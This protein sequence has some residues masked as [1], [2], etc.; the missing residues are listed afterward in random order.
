MILIRKIRFAVLSVLFFMSMIQESLTQANY[1]NTYNISDKE[2]IYFDD[3]SSNKGLKAVNDGV[4]EG[5]YQY[6]SFS[7][8]SNSTSYIAMSQLN[9]NINQSRDFEIEIDIKVVS[10]SPSF[11][12]GLI[13]GMDEYDNSYRFG[14]T[15]DG[16][17]KIYKKVEGFLREVKPL[18]Y[19]SL[20]NKYDYN[21]LTVRKVKDTYYFFINKTLVHSTAFEPFYGNNHYIFTFT[22]SHI[23]ISSIHL[24]YIARSNSNTG[25]I[26]YY[27]DFS[28]DKGLKANNDGYSKGVYNYKY[29]Q[30]SSESNIYLGELPLNKYINQSKDFQIE[31][32]MKFVSGRDNNGNGIRWGKS[33]SNYFYFQ[34]SGNGQFSIGKRVNNQWVDL[35]PWTKSS[36]VNTLNYNKLTIRKISSRYYFFINE[37]LVHE[38]YFE[39]F[40]GDENCLYSNI[41]STVHISNINITYFKANLKKNEIENLSATSTT[42]NPSFTTKQNKSVILDKVEIN[43]KYTVVTMTY[44]TDSDNGQFWFEKGAYIKANQKFYYL[45]KSDVG[46]SQ[47]DCNLLKNKG[48]SKTFKLYFLRIEEGIENI[49]IWESQSEG[50]FNFSG[51]KINNKAK[52]ADNQTFNDYF[53]AGNNATNDKN[54]E[55]SVYYFS[56]ALKIQPN[57]STAYN[58]RS[59]AKYLMGQCSGAISDADKSISLGGNEFSY[60][61]RASIYLCLDRCRDA[62]ND[63]DKAI[64]IAE[65]KKAFYYADRGQAQYCLGDYQNALNDYNQALKLEPNNAEYQ[66]ELADVKTKLDKKNDVQNNTESKSSLKLSQSW[67]KNNAKLTSDADGIDFT[68]A[69][70]IDQWKSLCDKDQ[71]AYCYYKFDPDNEHMGLIYNHAAVRIIAPEGFRVPSRKDF[72]IFLQDLKNSKPSSTLCAIVD[73]DACSKCFNCKIDDY[74]KAVNFK[75][76][77]YGWLSV[78]KSNKEKWKDNTEDIYFWTLE[79]TRNNSMLSG[80]GIAQ[81]KMPSSIVTVKLE[82]INNTGT[83]SSKIDLE[84]FEYIEKYFGT[85]VRFI[86]K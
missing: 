74:D 15:S 16:Y 58:N 44:T 7:L 50:A 65:E 62:L 71:A 2:T 12:N 9:Y 41:N 63:F 31:A 18:T 35:L 33:G 47:Y 85:Y 4:S 78:T 60:H 86:K 28:T 10:S 72:D 61:T 36:Y 6:R 80:L 29:Y 39:T 21:K 17:F 56:E 34:F 19:S 59:W 3:F 48:D 37:N 51:V 70:D 82:E 25:D 64:S 49:D 84:D 52:S 1:Y 68:L 24:S 79:S 46:L 14:I 55:L 77:P 5:E 81:F 75:L 53:N 66:K 30:L 83:K 73:K 20:V 32:T 26:I 8:K 43:S 42:Y 22:D 13:W 27:D 57:N 45:Q 76:V 40:Y 38:C 54:Y 67:T 11:P 23:K 69:D